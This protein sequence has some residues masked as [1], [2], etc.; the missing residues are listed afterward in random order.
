MAGCATGASAPQGSLF[1]RLG[2]MPAIEAVVGDTID[3]VVADARTRRSFDGIKLPALKASIAQQFC[4]LAGGPC[5]YEGEPSM[6]KAHRG[7]KVTDAEFDLM[8]AALRVALD[9]RVGTAE[10]NELL[11]LLAPMKRDIVGA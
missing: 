11:R 1:T 8:V 6:A 5:R 7:L 2:G 9:A 10:K 4:V 3:A